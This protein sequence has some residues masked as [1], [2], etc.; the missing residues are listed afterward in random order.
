MAGPTRNFW[1]KRFADG[2]T[3][4]DRDAAN[5][6]GLVELAAILQRIA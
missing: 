5:P 2:D 3:P 6:R 4:W 1:H